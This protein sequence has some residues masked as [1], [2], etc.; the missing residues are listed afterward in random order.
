VAEEEAEK[1]VSYIRGIGK[2]IESVTPPD[3]CG[4]GKET[5]GDLDLLVTLGSG[6]ATAKTVE[7]ATRNN[8][9]KYPEIDSDA[10]ARRE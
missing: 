2:A 7:A 1:L 10:G 3:R 4:A 9:L 8:I 5:V 6:K